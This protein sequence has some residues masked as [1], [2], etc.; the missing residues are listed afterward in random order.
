M[1]AYRLPMLFFC[2]LLTAAAFYVYPLLSKNVMPDT[3]SN[4][5]VISGNWSGKGT[6]Q[7]ASKIVSSLEADILSETFS[8]R[9]ISTIKPSMYTIEVE[10]KQEA[11]ISRAKDDLQNIIDR[12]SSWPV[13]VERPD[14]ASGESSSQL[15]ARLFVVSGQNMSP[16]GMAE[17]SEKHVVSQIKRIEGV[18]RI[19]HSNQPLERVWEL[20]ISPSL[21]AEFGVSM[22][23][24]ISTVSQQQMLDLGEVKLLDG[25]SVSVLIE[26]IESL[27]DLNNTM[28]KGGEI[29]YVPLS[30][31][32]TV[33]QAL[34]EEWTP[35]FYNGLPSFSAGIYPDKDSDITQTRDRIAKWSESI[36]KSAPD[37]VE[38]Y[39]DFYNVE[40]FEEG[41]L[42]IIKSVLFGVVGALL[43]FAFFQRKFIFSALILF[44]LIASLSSVIIAAYLLELQV[45]LISLTGVSLAIGL[46]MDAMVI[47]IYQVTTHSNV[48]VSSSVCKVRNALIS[49]TLT[50]VIVFMPLLLMMDVE[51]QMFHDLALVI[52]VSLFASTVYALTA[53]PSALSFCDLKAA[54]RR[55]KSYYA[56]I[57][58]RLSSGKLMYT[59]MGSV[60]VIFAGAMIF[61]PP[62]DLVPDP[63]SKM[64]MGLFYYDN[65]VSQNEV[66]DRYAPEVASAIKNNLSEVMPSFI[67]GIT[68][69]CNTSYCVATANLHDDSNIPDFESWFIERVG[70]DVSGLLPYVFPLG[71]F[72]ESL[73]EHRGIYI[74][75]TSDDQVEIS[76]ISDII[77]DH[78]QD[79][80]DDGVQVYGSGA[81]TLNDN[82]RRLR[83]N[84]NRLHHSGIQRNE[85]VK[86]AKA[87]TDGIFIGDKA[88]S[89]ESL[90][91]LLRIGEKTHFDQVMNFSVQTSNGSYPLSFFYDVETSVT[92]LHLLSINGVGKGSLYLDVPQGYP[93]SDFSEKLKDEVDSVLEENN[94]SVD[95][96]LRGSAERMQAFTSSFVSLTV[97]A[98]SLLLLTLWISMK[99]FAKA[100][101]V[102][103]PVP[104]AFSA[105][106]A[107][108]AVMNVWSGQTLDVIAMI[109]FII[110]LGLMVNNGILLTESYFEKLTTHL[111]EDAL[112]EAVKDRQY[113]IGM[114]TFTTI[115]GMSPLLFVSS[116]SADMY[117]GMAVVIISG[118][119]VSVT[120]GMAITAILLR[121]LSASMLTKSVI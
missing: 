103:S 53:L 118:M 86:Y 95:F 78:I 87:L 90:P 96:S 58:S 3:R 14:I 46:M 57:I 51:A 83:L 105:G 2:A 99:S 31:L 85:V 40:V 71:L 108:L 20:V 19:S 29:G 37:G 61:S 89:Q 93:L 32:V 55:S 77:T 10:L 84:E 21:V 69:Y 66:N 8:H 91:A 44:G 38:V 47:V 121:W 59:T 1:Q 107:M 97:M 13:D 79:S 80:F 50:S 111:P 65:P 54:K 102:L 106:I 36:R 16:V 28:I 64:V 119:L 35:T 116:Q 120:L 117:H 104:I 52:S 63:Q 109:G 67:E 26:Q 45:H 41:M 74:D 43:L 6:T 27:D 113:A 68:L 76:R 42:H 94:I 49:S 112:F 34:R 88:F 11:D 114:S 9:V 15:M 24:I 92:P 5:L 101:V 98:I 60:I 81:V 25:N 18:G 115:L 82:S 33:R 4:T 100:L 12:Q 48:S 30:K 75:F 62:Q 39:T 110:L 56:E 22:D 73:P 17:F 7:I 70:G 72:R 23:E